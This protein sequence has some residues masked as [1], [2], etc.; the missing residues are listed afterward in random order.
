MNNENFENLQEECPF[1]HKI[2][3][4]TEFTK[5]L[6]K[7]FARCKQYK[8]KVDEL[9]TK[10]YLEN[11]YLKDGKS[12]IELQ[13][14]IKNEFGFYIAYLKVKGL[15]EKYNIPL[16]DIHA[17]NKMEGRSNRIKKTCLEKYRRYKCIRKK[18]AII[19]KK[20]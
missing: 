12:I 6:L 13:E 5:N 1:C 15:L 18:F 11:L 19:S 7:H 9:I 20:K 16:R 3:K 17:A 14:S 2:I 4:Y 10:D 8:L